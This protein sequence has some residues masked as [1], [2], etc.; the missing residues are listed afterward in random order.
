MIKTKR[1]KRRYVSPLRERRRSQ[2][3][4][5]VLEA[6]TYLVA[7][8]GVEGFTVEEL[9]GRAQVSYASVY[10]YFP[11]RASLLE[12]L[13]QH[14]ERTVSA[15]I[16]PPGSL[17]ELRNV[18]GR[19]FSAFAENPSLVRG[20]VVMSLATGDRPAIALKR[21]HQVDAAVQRQ[22]PHLGERDRRL[23]SVLV[24]YLVSTIAF[25]SL[26][27]LHGLTRE[28][29]EDAISWAAESLLASAKRKSGQGH[30]AP[31]Q[32]SNP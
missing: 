25:I 5:A 31:S 20:L 17:E 12:G 22:L 3:R 29:A 18:V 32:R 24:C 27:D 26:T 28:E 2:T 1:K 7:E 23:F 16:D 21:D 9:A 11:T 13:Y 14:A 15:P 19:L 30:A 6:L 8:R 10:R 4:A